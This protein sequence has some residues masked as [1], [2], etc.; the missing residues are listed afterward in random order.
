MPS[1]DRNDALGPGLPLTPEIRQFL[2]E[3]YDRA[4]DSYRSAGIPFGNT[5]RGM[6]LWLEFGQDTTVS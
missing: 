5:V 6:L 1:K 3:I 4:W 2:E